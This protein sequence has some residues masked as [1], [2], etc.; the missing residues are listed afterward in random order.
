MPRV[1]TAPSQT[2]TDLF[3]AV[4]AHLRGDEADV[5]ALL[6]G[7]QERRELAALPYAAAMAAGEYLRDVADERDL[8]PGRLLGVLCAAHASLTGPAGPTAEGAILTGVAAY[9]RGQTQLWDDRD[10][11]TLAS[12]PHGSAVAAVRVVAA[13]LAWH[14]RDLGT[15]PLDAAQAT[16]LAMARRTCQD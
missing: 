2:L 13:A 8:V 16:C 15:E 14:A 12:D 11:E 9:L 6:R 3:A 4:T 10:Q 5:V 1:T 7:S